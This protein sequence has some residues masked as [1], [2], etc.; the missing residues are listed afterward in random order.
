MDWLSD[1]VAAYTA[2]EGR[3]VV[4][5]EIVRRLGRAPTAGEMAAAERAVKEVV[6]VAPLDVGFDQPHQVD[7]T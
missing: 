3:L 2:A 1:L 7:G 5:H 4:A 6:W